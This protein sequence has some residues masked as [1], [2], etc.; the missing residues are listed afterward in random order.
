MLIP[1][2]SGRYADNLTLL[3]PIFERLAVSTKYRETSFY[4]GQSKDAPIQ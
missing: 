2:M 4:R 1:N 3:L